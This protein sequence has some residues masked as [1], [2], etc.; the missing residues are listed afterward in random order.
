MNFKFPKVNFENLT[1]QN[2]NLK[3][4]LK[5]KLL[6]KVLKQSNQFT[7]FSVIFLTSLVIASFIMTLFTFYNTIT[8]ETADPKA[9]I[10][11]AVVLPFENFNP[12]YTPKNSVEE[13]ITSMLYHPL[14]NVEFSKFGNSQDGKFVTDTLVE[15][16]SW[17][18]NK[19]QQVLNMR[20]KDNL[21]FSDNSR[22]TSD[23]IKYTFDTIKS[24]KD[25]N[26][27][28]KKLFEELKLNV[29]NDL[30]FEF[31]SEFPRSSMIYELNFSPISKKY[32]EQVPTDKLLQSEQTKAPKVTSGYY[33]ISNNLVQ[34]KD[35][36]DKKLVQNPIQGQGTINFVKLESFKSKNVIKNALTSNWNIKKYD[37]VLANNI[38]QKKLSI[39]SDAKTNK[40]DLFIRSYEENPSNPDR[41]E[42]I[43][44]AT[45]LKQQVFD[46]NW[47]FTSYFNTKQ[48]ISRSKPSTKADFRNYASCL[49]IKNSTPSPYQS[50][51]KE[52][53]SITPLPLVSKSNPACNDKL[54][55]ANYKLNT[56]KVYEFNNADSNLVFKILYI[57]FDTNYEKEVN[58][59]FN[60]NPNGKIT[61][62]ITSL[63]NNP[64]KAKEAFSSSDKL[65]QYDM[66]LYPTQIKNTKLNQELTRS[67]SVLLG[68]SSDTQKLEELNKI[69]I[70]KNFNQNEVDNISKFFTEKSLIANIYNYKLEINHSFKKH[71][72]LNENG[73]ITNEFKSWYSKSVRDWFFK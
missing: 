73:I 16:I 34:D 38:S 29:I 64:E 68:S 44:K 54:N 56:N 24:S 67:N 46:N 62:E 22:I 26:R 43:T 45:S 18:E 51:V 4:F 72:E 15:K 47:Y 59:L 21:M 63:T 31:V 50:R 14:Y 65:A 27:N 3:V 12:I 32:F 58:K 53:K 28:F 41:P 8:K 1:L 36:S 71:I 2:V 42:E 66:I 52:D 55:D 39:E 10:N 17:S 35:Y 57:S 11:E 69:L 70:E 33:K 19:P 37:S 30:E 6:N 20:L 61:T 7:R 25:G 9:E 13:R 40:V 49:L 5:P 48:E 23:D 60:E